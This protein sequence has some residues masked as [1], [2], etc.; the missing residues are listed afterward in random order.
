MPEYFVIDGE[1]HVSFSVSDQVPEAFGS[2][3][4]AQKRARELAKSE[5]GLTV[6]ISQS[7]A[8]VTCE[9]GVPN[10]EMRERKVRK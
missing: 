4:K 9:V 10:I 8:W 1:G 5:P 7:V 2:F 6:V 3:A